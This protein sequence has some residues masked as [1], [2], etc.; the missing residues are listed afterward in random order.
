MTLSLN[1]SLILWWHQTIHLSELRTRWLDGHE[2][3]N[4]KSGARTVRV[5]G[6]G[7]QKASFFE[8]PS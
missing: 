3:P 4:F 7:T 2:L 1:D 6:L 8:V 5:G